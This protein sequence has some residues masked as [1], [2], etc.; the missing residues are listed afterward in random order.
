MTAPSPSVYD[1]IGADGIARVVAGFYRRVA[2]D[3]VLSLA[4]APFSI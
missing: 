2:E 4:P 1:Q 3:P